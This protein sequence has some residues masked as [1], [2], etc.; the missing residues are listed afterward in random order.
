MGINR[1]SDDVPLEPT[2]SSASGS[3]PGNEK[4][5]FGQGYRAWA[6]AFGSFMV[7][8]S[9]GGMINMYGVYQQAYQVEGKLGA[10]ES[11]ISWI[12][13][14]Q[15]SLCLVL[16]IIAGPLC[17]HGY[18]YYLVYSGIFFVVLGQMMLSLCT[19]YYQ[20][21]L[22]QGICMGFGSGLVFL[23][24]FCVLVPYFD[25]QLEIAVG[26]AAMGGGV[27]AIALQIIFSQIIDKVG[28]PWTTR[29]IGLVLM[30]P[31]LIAA[32]ILRVKKKPA[33]VVF[34]LGVVMATISITSPGYYIQGY[35]YAINIQDTA[36]ISYLLPIYMAAYTCGCFGL[37]ALAKW[38][39]PFN[40]TSV[41]VLLSGALSWAL[42]DLRNEGGLVFLVFCF[43]FLSAAVSSL[44][45]ACYVKM[46]PDLSRVGSRMGCGYV[47]STIGSL[48]GAPIAGAILDRYR[49]N[50][51]WMFTA[52]MSLAG[53]ALFFISRGLYGGWRMRITA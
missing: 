37:N 17:D 53:G 45:P 43:G 35:A 28:F 23:P 22:S 16:G 2:G 4:L 49:Y 18:F 38:L 40:V 5:I 11:A 19:S 21:F 8:F 36:L 14:V 7:F 51:L 33:S 29:V 39:G 15:S 6:Q 3:C 31:L 10:S 50:A 24:A 9:I 47:A 25:R 30:V 12:G 32:A 48:V 13:S 42:V 1:N 41:A 34:L 44:P 27:G 26:I 52:S 20:I 46:C